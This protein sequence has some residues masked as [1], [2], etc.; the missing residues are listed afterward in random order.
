[1]HAQAGILLPQVHHV[2]PPD[3]LASDRTLDAD[4]YG[5]AVAQATE[6]E[7]EA[8]GAD[9]VAAFIGEPIQG[10]GGVI[11]PP[12]SYWPAIERICR[13]HNVLLIAD[14][15]ITGFGRTGAMFAHQRFGYSPDIVIMAKQLSSGYFPISAVGL[16][17]R[18]VDAVEASG[19]FVHGYTYSGHP[20]GAAVALRNLQIM[21]DE[22]LV[23]A[24]AG[25]S[26]AIFASGLESIASHPLVGNARAC[27][28]L[29]A[30]DLVADKATRR[31]HSNPGELARVVRDHAWRRG[32]IVRPIGEAVALCPPLIISPSELDELFS[33]LRR[34]L[35]DTLATMLERQGG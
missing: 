25:A 8:V 7:I 12:S 4:A 22:G 10:A 9:N 6:Q 14:E 2:A 15:V 24:A 31:R 34:A 30:V 33:L 27:G 18:V 29:G 28:L 20:V 35:D 5:L 23:A 19:L 21:E 11:I 3:H 16:S 13:R 17:R 32:L 1:M 26:G